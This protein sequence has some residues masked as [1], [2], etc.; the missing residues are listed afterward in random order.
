MDFLDR[1]KGQKNMK[2]SL[3]LMKKHYLVEILFFEK[4]GKN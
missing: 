2:N 3:K 1:L 4:I